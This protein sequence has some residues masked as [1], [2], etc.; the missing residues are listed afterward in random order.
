M[1]VPEI[2]PIARAP[3]YRTDMIGRYAHG[4]FL[5]SITWAF[6][7]GVGIP[8]DWPEH[9]RLY[10]V[11]HRF[12]RDGHHLNS[13]IWFAGTWAEKQQYPPD[14]DPVLARAKLKMA[15]LLGSLPELEYGDIAIRPFRLNVDGVI[16]GL[17]VHGEHEDEDDWA[18][19]QLLPD[20]LVFHEPWDGRYDT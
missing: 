3:N 1:T 6:R 4:I 5:A 13:D 12:D 8:E 10:T 7:E 18:R 15:E 19:V 17:I 9:K 14:K 11:L 2:I 20:G 16:F